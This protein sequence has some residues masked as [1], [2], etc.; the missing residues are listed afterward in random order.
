MILFKLMQA[1]ARRRAT[2]KLAQ[3]ERQQRNIER[4]REM[5]AFVQQRSPWYRQIIASHGIDITTCTPQDFPVLT[6]SMVRE[7]F[8]NIVTDRAIT[9]A[10]MKK[11]VEKFPSPRN[12]YLGRYHVVAS[13]GSSGL[14]AYYIHSTDELVN[15]MSYG[16]FHRKLKPRMRTTFI[17]ILDEHKMSTAVMGLMDKWP[18]RILFNTRNFDV[19]S[20]W[21][22]IV[23]GINSHQPH[24]ISAYKHVLMRLAE[25]A[26]AGNLSIRPVLL[27]SGGEPLF[28]HE[29]E[30]LR[31]T[32]KCEI[33]N[34]Y[35]SSEV[36]MMGVALNDWDCMYLFEDDLMFELDAEATY[37]TNLYN[38]T[39]PLIR[40]RFDDIL[41]P[42]AASEARL[43][44]R[45]V[46][47]RIGRAQELISF[48]SGVGADRKFKI[49]LFEDVDFAGVHR[50]EFRKRDDASL[51]VGAEIS[52][53]MGLSGDGGVA[54]AGQRLDRLR[55]DMRRHLDAQGFEDVGL[56][57]Y[58]LDRRDDQSDS[59]GKDAL[60]IR[61]PSHPGRN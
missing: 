36:N 11:F 26:R 40:Y 15:G 52:A 1:V 18:E 46:S 45:A 51:E 7:H 12:L 17:G 48:P 28:Q 54:E 23:D 6:T 34:S 32:F 47:E 41:I 29:R 9:R 49:M 27:E 8:D 20:S 13:S 5:A 4:F 56:N 53:S 10:G 3:E 44:F 2:L 59:G 61:S 37:V 58:L 16:I 22:Q 31:A 14:P 57:V 39:L 38:R 55:M 21:G 42:A 24:V 19:R 33:A 35:G 60:V 30:F 25:D 50:L 43:P